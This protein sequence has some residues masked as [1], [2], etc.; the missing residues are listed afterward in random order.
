MTKKEFLR[1]AMAE[2]SSDAT[3]RISP[4]V[5]ARL[6]NNPIFD[7]HCHIFDKDCIT[8]NYFLLRLLDNLDS[9]KNLDDALEFII[10]REKDNELDGL[11]DIMNF[12]NMQQILDYYINEYAYKKNIICTPLMMDLS[13]GWYFKPKKSI[14]DQI[15]ELKILMNSEAI[16]PFLAIDPRKAEKH[17][18]DN[19]Y[20]LFMHAFTGENKFYGVKIY[21]ALGYLPSDPRLMPIYEIC[22][23]KNIPVT[24]HCGG[25]II[26][27]NKN[28][29]TVKGLQIIN[30]QVVSYMDT[31]HEKGKE[32]ANRLNNPLLWEP[33]LKTYKKLKLNFGHFGGYSEWKNYPNDTKQNRIREINRLMRE[34]ENLYA[35][36][37]FNITKDETFNNFSHALD[38]NQLFRERAMFGTDYWVVLPSGN[39]RKNQKKFITQINQYKNLLMQTNPQNFLFG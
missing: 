8:K 14:K 37:S 27:T 33:V 36:F 13:E 23:A 12:D 16:M 29:F 34:Y 28:N 11:F 22:E 21:P 19:L 35:D 20:N 2:I 39:F 3:T 1:K 9:D 25:T 38:N 30:N 17:G 5:K 4:I 15:D 7:I 6:N 32:K 18:D 24:S 31:I 10:D 26:R